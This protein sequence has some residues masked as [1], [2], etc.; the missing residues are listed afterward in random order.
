[1]ETVGVRLV[2]SFALKAE[3]LFSGC[4]PLNRCFAHYCRI[5]MGHAAS[6]PKQLWPGAAPLLHTAE[7]I[8]QTSVRHRLQRSRNVVQLRDLHWRARS[9][10]QCEIFGV[11]LLRAPRRLGD[12]QRLPMC[13]LPSSTQVH[14]LIYVRLPSN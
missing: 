6:S 14:A 13:T 8:V 2:L 3:R 4:I 9:P 7:L 5:G 11:G 12:L 1:M 10:K